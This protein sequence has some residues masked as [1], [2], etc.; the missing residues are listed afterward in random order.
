MNHR[1][2]FGKLFIALTLSLFCLSGLAFA[3]GEWFMTDNG[4]KVWHPDP[5]SRTSAVWTG[6][7]DTE[8]YAS[9]KGVLKWYWG[10][11]DKSI[12]E[13]YEGHMKK[14]KYNG[15]GIY[16]KI[17][18]VRNQSYEGDFI[19][20]RKHGYG[21]YKYFNTRYEGGWKED[22]WDGFGTEYDYRG[23]RL[24]QGN[25][26]AGQFVGA[27]TLDKATLSFSN[28]RYEGGVLNGKP[29]GRGVMAYS[30]GM[31]YDGDWVNGVR[32]GKGN[33]TWP[34]G[35]RYEGEFH[36]SIYGQ[37]VYTW[38]N[39]DRYE[40]EFVDDIRTGN[41]IVVMAN[42]ERIEKLY[43]DGRRPLTIEALT[44]KYPI[45][46]KVEVI[47][48]RRFAGPK[49]GYAAIVKDID[50]SNVTL[51][52]TDFINVNRDIEPSPA[53]G[54]K[55]LVKG[56]DVGTEVTTSIRAITGYQG[57]YFNYQET[58]KQPDNQ[59]NDNLKSTSVKI[60]MSQVFATWEMVKW[61]LSNYNGRPDQ[62]SPGF[63]STSD[64]PT[65]RSTILI[66]GP[67][68]A[69]QYRWSAT[70]KKASSDYREY[71]GIITLSGDKRFYNIVI[72]SEGK[73]VGS[74]EY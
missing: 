74:G 53:T 67:E 36:N 33:F 32:K 27:G 12:Y 5:W 68:L 10:G 44:E 2:K 63:I 34:N 55:Y 57:T 69:G 51:E 48:W 40:G 17:S 35:D 62:D 3:E 4:V 56:R 26:L 47:R 73:D 15:K 60:E 6:A 65:K 14:G 19:E 22:N 59:P 52:V 39:G 24:R 45:D 20:G 23:R 42:G 61:S 11:A 18:N 29:H 37:G 70:F 13:Q 66:T 31:R 7:S 1:G 38:A 64:S 16:T 72:N 41:G 43:V 71:S 58:K 25:W 8:G 49:Y 28:G 46:S 30:N 50:G 21:V 9:G 54:G